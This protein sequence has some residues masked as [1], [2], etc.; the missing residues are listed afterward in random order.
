[1]IADSSGL[2]APGT[3]LLRSTPVSRKVYDVAVIGLG[4]MGAGTA[5]QLAR[6]GLTVIGFDAFR[7]PHEMGSSHGRSRIIR[8]AYFENPVYVPLVQRAYGLWQE[9]EAARHERLLTICGGVMIGDPS[10]PLVAGARESA[11]QHGLP[12]EEWSSAD[13]STRIAAIRPGAGM[14]GLFEPRAGVLSPE[15]GVQAMLDEATAFGA[16]LRFD[17]PVTAVASGNG[18]VTIET[19]TDGPTSAK[20]A[21][22]APGGWLP[23]LLP[24]L[25]LPL[26][27][28]RAVQYWFRPADDD[29]FAP[30]RFPIFLLETPD[31]RFLYGLPDQGNGLKLAEHHGGQLSSRDDVIRR[32]DVDEAHRF[33]A[34]VETYFPTLPEGPVESS[35]CTYTNT[36]DGHFVLDRHPA[37][38]NVYL[39]SACSGHGF[40]FA[41]A[42]GELVADTVT[43]R[44]PRVDTRFFRIDRFA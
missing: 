13:I 8:E 32:V 31:D 29:R 37:Q 17:T 22:C 25:A 14:I 40:K 9:L 42:I 11:R 12:V 35:V 34:F 43:G 3:A 18:T 21:V 30:A 38:A 24:D 23:A 1:M 2:R 20:V 7:P 15:R 26:T 44:E 19:Q 4:A 28:E 6:R 27:I 16:D 10:G 36:P 41:P 33:R 39:V 5:W